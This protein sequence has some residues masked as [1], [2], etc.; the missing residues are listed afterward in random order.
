MNWKCI[1]LAAVVGLA[2]IWAA[3]SETNAQPPLPPVEQIIQRAIDKAQSESDNDRNFNLRYAYTRTK[4][5]AFLNGDGTI[6]TSETNCSTNNP[7]RVRAR[8]A[9]RAAAEAARATPD[10]EVKPQDVKSVVHGKAFQKKDFLMNPDILNRFNFVLVGRQALNG[11][12]TLVIDFKPK[13][14]KLPERNLKERFINRAAGRVWLDEQDAQLAK[15]DLHLTEKVDVLAGVVGSVWKFTCS[16]NRDRTEDGLW[17]TR[18]SAW[19]LEGREVVI[20]RI[21]D[22]HDW[23]EDVQRVP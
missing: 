12:D 14:G 2:S 5:K 18:N 10:K 8:L 11:R 20:H 17:F 9:A 7:I 3:Q 23:T 13:P 1:S 16:I 4:V 21:V 19:H 22:Y 6:S 15:A